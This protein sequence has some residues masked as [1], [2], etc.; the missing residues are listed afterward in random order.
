MAVH[1]MCILGGLLCKDSSLDLN[2]MGISI[3]AVV[4]SRI[5]DVHQEEYARKRPG[6]VETIL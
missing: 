6:I 1:D 5:S 2:A 3:A 4:N